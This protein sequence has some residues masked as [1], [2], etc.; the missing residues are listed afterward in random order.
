MPWQDRALTYVDQIPE[1]NYASR[2]YA[3]M[4]RQLRLYPAIL[5][6]ND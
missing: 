1:L 4:L 2:F 3:R 5:D 6:E